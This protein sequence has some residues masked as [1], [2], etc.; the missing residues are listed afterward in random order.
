[1]AT[2]INGILPA[3]T[4]A[5]AFTLPRMGGGTVTLPDGAA[6]GLTLLVFYKNT[7]PTCR[8]TF[9]FV[10]R[11]HEQVVGS[12]GRVTAISQDGAEGAA[13]FAKELGLTMPI[14]VDGEDWPVSV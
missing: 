12:G 1:M 5:P 2:A 6:K 3:G 10:Q 14:A 4:R 11:I 9:P 7:C 8:M 13:S